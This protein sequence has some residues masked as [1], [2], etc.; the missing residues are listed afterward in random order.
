MAVLKPIKLTIKIKHYWS[1]SFFFLWDYT[2]GHRVSQ[3]SVS[4]KQER[5]ILHQIM[6]FLLCYSFQVHV[7]I[8]CQ[9]VLYFG[10]YLFNIQTLINH[11]KIIKSMIS[12]YLPNYSISPTDYYGFK[13]WKLLSLFLTKLYRWET[14]SYFDSLVAYKISLFVN[15]EL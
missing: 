15:D 3:C 2:N 7:I 14:N 10:W 6:N 12:Y 9:W 8:N 1:K 4:A 5:M 13:I 11:H